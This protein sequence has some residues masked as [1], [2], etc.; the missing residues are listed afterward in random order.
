LD[1]CKSFC[2]SLNS[3][4]NTNFFL[5]LQGWPPNDST[6]FL[7]AWGGFCPDYDKIPV[8]FYWRME[9]NPLTK[10]CV[11]LRVAPGAENVCCEHP[12]VHPNFATRSASYSYAQC[13]NV[14]G[15]ASAPMGLVKLT[16]D[17]SAVS[18]PNLRMGE[19][20]EN[21]DA[22]WIGPRRF[23]GEPLVIPK[24]NGN[25]NLEE[26]AYLLALV[27]DAVKDRSSLVVF[28]LERELKKGPVCTL[29]L[30]TA[31]PHG[32]HGSFDP[33]STCQSSYFC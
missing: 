12:V 6:S 32:L 17:R 10:K 22:Y 33:S 30:K 20:N 13:C 25:I 31:L 21:V 2:T 16:L 7:G 28:D 18:Q 4:L 9:I 23:A 8:T 3:D 27:Y 5:I 19:K 11:D 15:D 14:V 24:H 26:D 29:W 1:Y